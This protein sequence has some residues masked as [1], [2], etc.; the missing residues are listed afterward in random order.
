MNISL[1][2]QCD[3]WILIWM[4]FLVRALL[5]LSCYQSQR[6]IGATRVG[7][8]TLSMLVFT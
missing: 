8:Q 3:R 1:N 4:K 6:A 7:I 5:L 2:E